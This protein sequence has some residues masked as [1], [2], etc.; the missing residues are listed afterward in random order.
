MPGTSPGADDLARRRPDEPTGRTNARPSARND[1]NRTTSGQFGVA[2]PRGQMLA[3]E[4]VQ[5]ASLG[6]PI[7]LFYAPGVIISIASSCTLR[8]P[9]AREDGHR[10]ILLCQDRAWKDRG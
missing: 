8:R 9:T 3:R 6:S 10:P 7:K 1:D 2:N 4:I 5:P